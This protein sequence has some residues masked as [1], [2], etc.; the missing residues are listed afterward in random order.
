MFFPD[1]PLTIIGCSEQFT[2]YNPTT[3]NS[4]AATNIT[5]AVHTT[6]EKTMRIE[7]HALKLKDDLKLNEKQFATLKLLL[8]SLSSAGS[9]GIMLAT[10][11]TSALRAKKDPGMQGWAQNEIPTNQWQH[12]VGY[13]VNIGLATLQ[14]EFVRFATGPQNLDGLERGPDVSK[15]L[16]GS[17]M[18]KHTEFENFRRSGFISLAALGGF[19]V[20]TPWVINK[21]L[22]RSGRRWQWPFVLEWISYGHMQLLRMAN[23]GAGVEG[24]KG[25]DEKIPS[26]EANRIAYI[27]LGIGVGVG[28][29]GHSPPH[30]RMA[31]S[32]PATDIEMQTRLSAA[33]TVKPVE[34]RNQ[35][36]EVREYEDFSRLLDVQPRDAF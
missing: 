9:I 14:L 29:T 26:I 4:S 18:I 10:I 20:L 21:V 5:G 22:V 23:E 32:P 34:Q 25:C 15:L 35:S 8:W 24:W 17:Q 13:W 36:Q 2:F 28:M 12:E 33:S 27:D 16:C 6:K 31:Y 1:K 19:L 3:K 30:P 11:G 7:K